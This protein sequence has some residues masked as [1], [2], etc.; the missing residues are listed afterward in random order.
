M[1]HHDQRKFFLDAKAS[2]Y[3][4]YSDDIAREN[5][6]LDSR[7]WGIEARDEGGKAS[8]EGRKAAS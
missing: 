5:P 2:D 1:N 4:Q 8:G 3:E 6:S 7:K